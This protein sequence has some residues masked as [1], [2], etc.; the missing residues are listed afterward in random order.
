[1]STKF[2]IENKYNKAVPMAN[3]KDGKTMPNL[4]RTVR[5]NGHEQLPYRLILSLLSHKPIRIDDIRPDD[6]E[7]GLNGTA[8]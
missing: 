8:S 4:S 3:N 5:F 1:V 6:Q 7:P 2:L